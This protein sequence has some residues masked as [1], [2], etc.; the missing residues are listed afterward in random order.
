MKNF[1]L[2]LLMILLLYSCKS[3]QDKVDESQKDKD[4]LKD[5]KEN[6]VEKVNF[7]FLGFECFIDENETVEDKNGFF[8]LKYKIA[9][10]FLNNNNKF[11]VEYDIF[12][13]DNNNITS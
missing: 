5:N 8:N 6:A 9:F 10:N 13:R 4:K 7:D 1:G 3:M 2:I 11:S 12:D